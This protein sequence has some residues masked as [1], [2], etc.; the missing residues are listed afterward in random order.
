MMVLRHYKPGYQ[1][2]AEE[3]GFSAGNA[4]GFLAHIK[5]GLDGA[6]IP[7]SARIQSADDAIA[8]IRRATKRRGGDP[9]ASEYHAKR[10]GRQWHVTAWHI[11]YPE[12]TG[13]SRFVPGGFTSYTVSSDGRIVDTMPGL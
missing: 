5:Q 6:A 7:R 8:V 2:N 4:D 12:N 1:R 13:S 10:T 3:Q 9:N 11:W